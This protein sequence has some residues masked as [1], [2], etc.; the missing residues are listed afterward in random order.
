MGEV[1]D[2]L[3]QLRKD[4]V[5][6]DR[7]ATALYEKSQELEG[8]INADGEVVRGVRWEY[9]KAWD[10]ELIAFEERCNKRGERLPAVDIRTARV[11]RAVLEANPELCE[12][13]YAL[14]ATVAQLQRL[15]SSRKSAVSA[16]Q[17]IL[18]GEA[19]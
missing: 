17:S 10:D 1:I 3:G 8:G 15:I 12:R 4:S 14:E 5:R 9:E 18:K 19:A 13:F 2:I 16:N 11:K 7:A 6:I